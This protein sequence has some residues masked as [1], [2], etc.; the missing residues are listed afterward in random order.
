MYGMEVPTVITD[1]DGG[2]D[3]V[4]TRGLTRCKLTDQEDV[5]HDLR[6]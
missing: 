3:S 5:D 1:S 6:V 4:H 2:L